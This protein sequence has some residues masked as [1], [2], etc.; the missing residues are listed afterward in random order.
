MDHLEHIELDA[1]HPTPKNRAHGGIGDLTEMTASVK[2]HG[3]LEPLLVRVR[4]KG[5]YW[6]VAGER[7]WRS[8]KGAGLDR[9]PCIL[10]NLTDEQAVELAAIENGQ[11]LDAH[12]L[13]EAEAFQTLI[14]RGRTVDAIATNLGR[15]SAYVRQRLALMEP[16]PACC[17][18]LND[19]QITAAVAMMLA[20]VP[21]H[22]LQDEALEQVAREEHREPLNAK[23]ALGE[24]RDRFMLKLVDAPFDRAAVGLVA[25]AGACT[26]CPKRTGNQAELFSDVDS[27]DLCTDPVCFRSKLDAHWKITAAAAKKTGQKVLSDTEAKGVFD[28]FGAQSGESRLQWNAKWKRLTDEEWAGGKRV[29]VKKLLGDKLPETTLARDPY[30][31][32]LHE[33]V[34]VA[35]VK[36]ALARAASQGSKANGANGSSRTKL[37]PA[38]KD[39]KA[40]ERAKVEAKD[41]IERRVFAA[42][43]DEV[44]RS[45]EAGDASVF[46]LI[47]EPMCDAFFEG[48]S[49]AAERR[50]LKPENKKPFGVGRALTAYAAKGSTDLARA[51]VL[52]IVLG[53]FSAYGAAREDQRLAEACKAFEI[54]RKAIEKAVL[55][56]LKAAKDATP[57]PLERKKA[58]ASANGKRDR[59][60]PPKPA[61]AKRSS[62]RSAAHA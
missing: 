13:D 8:A 38:E 42:L 60:A 16:S 57:A 14:N 5:G 2:E 10:H 29:K 46:L 28:R 35:A 24:I 22:K 59:K 43:V 58:P 18:A 30:T 37:S 52:E 53:D 4:Q 51:L 36:S 44:E 15:S 41:L 12:P 62:K 48:A 19:G 49:K 34:P 45:A 50:G 55:A 17:Q 11:R 3:V 1:L 25:K 61:K 40:R 56:E 39:A 7:R 27:P 6:I 54:D 31:G 20:R 33:L 47:V 23:A 21:T 9:V 26:V 32:K